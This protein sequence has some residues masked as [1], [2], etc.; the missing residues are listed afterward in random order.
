MRGVYG[1]RPVRAPS[2]DCADAAAVIAL[3]AKPSD[4]IE[5]EQTVVLET[6]GRTQGGPWL[7]PPPPL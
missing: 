2:D 7:H 1:V 5:A 3:S 4:L 6:A